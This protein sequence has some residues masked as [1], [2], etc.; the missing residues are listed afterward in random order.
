MPRSRLLRPPL[1]LLAVLLWPPGCDDGGPTRGD[2][3]ADVDG[4]AD[5]DVDADVDVGGDADGDVDGDLD[6]DAYGDADVEALVCA[7]NNGVSADLELA[8]AGA[9]LVEY[10]AYMGSEVPY[11]VLRVQIFGEN[12]AAVGPG[13]YEL[14]GTT[15]DDCEVCVSVLTGCYTG[16]CARIFF[17]VAG[18]IEITAIGGEGDRFAGHL[19]GI[20]MAEFEILADGI[21]TEPLPDGDDWCIPEHDFD[22][23]AT[24]THDAVCGRPTVPCL[25]ETL[26]DFELE[27]CETGEMVSMTSLAAGNRALVFTMVTGW[28]PYCAEW[29]RTLGGYVTDYGSSGLS[30]AYVYGEDDAATAPDATECLGYAARYGADP[31]SFFLDHDGNY[32]FTTTTWA[33]WPWVVDSEE[34]GLPWSTIVDAETLQYVFT[35]EAEPPPDFETV[36]RGLLEG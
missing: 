31:S 28:C 20:E 27:S 17:A 1:A 25:D 18:R 4:D 12:V 24:S 16:P 13:V 35:S 9:D 32:S 36:M 22:M 15:F 7:V 2:G 23:T 29:M 30:V 26:L 10:R 5:A 8:G 19:E 6:G 33:M 11:E 3:D 14:A 34:L 21:G